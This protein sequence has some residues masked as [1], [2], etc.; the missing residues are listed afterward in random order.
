MWAE[1]ANAHTQIDHAPCGGYNERSIARV[2][3]RQH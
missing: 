1:V 2:G 3:R